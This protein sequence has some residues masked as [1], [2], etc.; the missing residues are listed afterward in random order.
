MKA[1][2]KTEIIKLWKQK[3]YDEASELILRASPTLVKELVQNI[4]LKLLSGQA[5]TYVLGIIHLKEWGLNDTLTFNQNNTHII[6]PLLQ[7]KYQEEFDSANIATKISMF[8]RAKDDYT[9][10]W[11]GAENFL[12]RNWQHLVYLI[13]HWDIGV[14]VYQ[15]LL[16]PS[17]NHLWSTVA[18]LKT[19]RVAIKNKDVA[20]TEDFYLTLR[21]NFKAEFNDPIR[22]MLAGAI[23]TKMEQ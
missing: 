15:A 10:L 14:Q 8:K 3:N 23:L 13:S 6:M 2:L 9:V 21:Q 11:M 19:I 16:M 22:V 17:P 18:A 1:N 7:K 4:E 20:E 5:L 12:N